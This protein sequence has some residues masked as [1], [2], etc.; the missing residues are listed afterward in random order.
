MEIRIEAQFFRINSASLGVN[1]NFDCHRISYG[2][3]SLKHHL[4]RSCCI[5]SHSHF[6]YFLYNH[7]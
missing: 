1:R 5:V 7:P 4:Y 6:P 3:S 2:L